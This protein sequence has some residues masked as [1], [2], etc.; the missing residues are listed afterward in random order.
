M[1]SGGVGQLMPTGKTPV[2]GGW[3]G[4]WDLDFYI[5]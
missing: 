2:G 3:V 4:G 5:S 1:G